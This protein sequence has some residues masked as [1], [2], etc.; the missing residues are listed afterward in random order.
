MEK[1]VSFMRRR[2]ILP[3]KGSV[4]L[5]AVSGGAD[6]VCLLHVMLELSQKEGFRVYAAHF[7]HGLRGEEAKR[8]EDFVRALCQKWSV[9]CLFGAG[10]TKARIYETGETVE[11][12]AR[13]LRY[14]FLKEAA[15]KVGAEKIATAHTAN[16][17]AETVIFR[18]ARGTG[19]LGLGGIPAAREKY[20]RPLLSVSRAEVE[21]YL[22]QRDIPFVTDSTNADTQYARNFVRAEILP[23]LEKINQRAVE[24][25][26]RGAEIMARE[27]DYLQGLALERMAALEQG[28][29]F[30]ALPLQDILAAPEV[31][32]SRMVRAMADALGVGKKDLGAA[33]VEEILSLRAEGACLHL[34]DMQASIEGGKLILRWGKKEQR[35]TLKI[36]GRCAYM[37]SVFS[38]REWTEMSEGLKITVPKGAE[39]ILRP[40]AAKDRFPTAKGTRGVKRLLADAGFT[41]AMREN[42][43]AVEAD[44]KLV[45]VW[46]IG[47]NESVQWEGETLTVEIK[48]ENDEVHYA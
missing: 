31:L 36:G 26:C 11:E 22:A 38:A 27:S 5:C 13:A 41:P 34:R 25:I 47:A 45:A 33:Q 20:I 12:G 8:D 43:P 16:D 40:C 42:C 3:K 37:Q 29:R 24:N 15:E 48:K 17:Q 30:V 19:G 39:L 35:A 10:D 32:Q 46:G 28:E 1:A 18:L 23:A 4:V 9:T 14:A 7:N 6:S 21:A 44:G 2:G